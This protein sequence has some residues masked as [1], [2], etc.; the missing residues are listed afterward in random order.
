MPTFVKRATTPAELESLRVKAEQKPV[1]L[2]F[3]SAALV[4][5]LY[6]AL[7]SDLHNTIDFY[8]A[9]D[10]KVGEEAMNKFGVDK[11]PALVFLSGGDKVEKYSG[12]LKFDEIKAWLKPLSEGA[13]AAREAARQEL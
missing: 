10:A 11:V 2:L 1:A 7:S 8:A 4:T 6:K 13:P 12:A 5:P 9:R 3:T